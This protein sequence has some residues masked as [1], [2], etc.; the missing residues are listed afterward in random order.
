MILDSNDSHHFQFF[1]E[2]VKEAIA[3]YGEMNKDQLLE[4]QREQV[5]G[6]SQLEL[7]FIEALDRCGRLKEA[8]D[9]FYDYVLLEKKNLLSARPFFRERATAF[10]TGI[11]TSIKNRDHSLTVKYHI[12]FHFVDLVVKKLDFSKNKKV[13]EVASKIKQLRRDLVLMNLPLIISRARIFYSRT[14]KSHLSFMDFVQIGVGGLLSA[15]DKYAGKYQKVWRGV[16]IGRC[17]GDL[18]QNFSQ[19]VL[20]FYPEDRKRLY[21]A[22][23]YLARHSKEEINEQELLDLVNVDSDDDK[24]ADIDI[25][26]N[27]LQ[28]AGVVSVDVRPTLNDEKDGDENVV[29]IAAPDE[30]RPDCAFELDESLQMMI[31]NIRKL[32]LEDQKILRLKGI[33]FEIAV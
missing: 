2:Q 1:A 30:S 31:R 19:T 25:M 8:F 27:L 28:A 33:E 15:I 11:M 23:K 7:D 20:H 5:D 26:R 21:R 13:L 16:V 6:L 12:N 3:R 17:T 22:N 14:P 32:P 29:R 24:K 10:A 4:K 9:C 18:I